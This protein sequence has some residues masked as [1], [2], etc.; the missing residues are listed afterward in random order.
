MSSISRAPYSPGVSNTQSH[1]HI[2]GSKG[3]LA[4]NPLDWLLSIFGSKREEFVEESNPSQPPKVYCKTPEY[5]FGCIFKKKA[6]QIT[7]Q[8]LLLYAGNSV[9]Y[10]ER[11]FDKGKDYN[12]EI[13]KYVKFA[14]CANSLKKIKA[15]R[16]DFI[17][18]SASWSPAQLAA[19]SNELDTEYFN[20]EYTEKKLDSYDGGNSL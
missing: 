8:Q 10:A 20:C 12:P 13:R 16:K 17:S 6:G 5:N 7:R 14:A 15:L 1:Q 3:D 11:I 9:T 2:N 4:F 19:K 18:N